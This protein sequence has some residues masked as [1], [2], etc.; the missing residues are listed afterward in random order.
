MG[1]SGEFLNVR[2]VFEKMTKFQEGLVK[3]SFIIIIT[4]K[5]IN[6]WDG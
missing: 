1:V 5:N 2:G 6:V 4:L 3:L